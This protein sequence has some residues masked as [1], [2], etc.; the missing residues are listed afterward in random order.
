M[1]PAIPPPPPRVSGQWTGQLAGDT[2]GL[3]V[4]ELEQE[5]GQIN[6]TAYFYPYDHQVVPALVRFSFAP[7]L[8][9]QHFTDLPVHPLAPELGAVITR[10]QMAAL[11]P[12]SDVSASA[13]LTLSFTAEGVFVTFNTALVC[14]FGNL[15][16]GHTQPS[17]LT[18][19]PMTW[20]QFKG[21]VTSWDKKRFVYR[22]QA[23]P[24]RLR[25]SFHRTWRKNLDTY[26]SLLVRETHKALASHL[27]QP[28]DFT[29]P[30]DV[31]SFYSM[32][33]HHG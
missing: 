21:Q 24:W 14:G 15:T 1:I 28:L 33:Q 22:G 18:P 17:R 13:S 4:L 5:G 19:I 11:Y 16:Q 32:I 12:L 3:G 29:R 26:T 2:P 27:T 7:P 6:G 31:G 20:E 30:D 23:Q 25:T 9:N 8:S 10:E